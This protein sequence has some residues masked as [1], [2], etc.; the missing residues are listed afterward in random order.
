MNPERI[1]VG[2]TTDP[3][4]FRL[5]K[6]ADKSP[7]PAGTVPTVRIRK[8]TL[9]P[10]VAPAG[11]ILE[12]GSG[13]GRFQVDADAGD[14][15]TLGLLY[16]EATA[17]DCDPSVVVYFIAARE[18]QEP[19]RRYST[20]TPLPFL[21]IEAGTFS[22]GLTG[23]SPTV[24]L[25]K[26]SGFVAATG[27]VAEVGSGGVGDGLYQLS[28][29]AADVADAV[30]LVVLRATATGADPV[31]YEFDFS[32]GADPSALPSADCG[33]DVMERGM[34]WLTDQLQAHV[35][36]PIIYARGNEVIEFCATFGRKLFQ[37]QDID[38]GIRM[39]WS[40]RDFI[41]PATS[42]D[43]GGGPV[44]PRRGDTVTVDL[45][46]GTGIVYEVAAPGGEQ[47][48][49]WSD[50]FKKSLRVHAKQV[51]TINA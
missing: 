8:T 47:P 17:T 33:T 45:G 5:V 34:A 36:Q 40:D 44:L 42:L 30:G 13:L 48:Y 14:V 3:L 32:P 23:A 28:P 41:F 49:R 15:D 38:G 46:D 39:Q 18:T 11:A 2:S 26:G 35:A 31:T 29:S 7:A 6:S 19:Y 50:P 25:E 20:A 22:T 16:L 9:S 1:V 43:F 12:V 51:E 10:W 24:T 4:K 21:L 37:L 27:T